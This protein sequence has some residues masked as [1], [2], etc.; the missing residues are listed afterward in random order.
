MDK[1]MVFE[2]QEMSKDPK[3]YYKILELSPGAS[4][5]DVKRAYT[6]QQ[7]K[8]H[9]DSPY[10]KDRLRKAANDQEREKIRKECDEISSQLNS[11]KSVLF[12]EKRKQ[13]Y[14]SGMGEFGAQFGAGN[15]SDIFDIFSQFTGGRGQQRQN[16]MNPTKYVINISLRES[17]VGK[18]SKFNVKTEKI[19][20]KCDGK[21][22]E[23]VET[24][25]KC[26]G[27]GY[28]TSRR[29][30]GGFVTVAES[31]CDACEG[32]GYK[33]K[34]K[35]C[36]SC[37]GAEY[38]QDK[39]LFEVNIKPG[40]RKG[41]KIVFEGMGDQRRRIAPGDVIFIVDVQDDSRFERRGDDLVGKID[42]PLRTAIGGGVVYFNHIDGR[43]LEITVNPFRTFDTVLKIRNEGFRGQRTGNLVLKPNIVIGSEADRAKIM[44]ALDAPVEK[45]YGAFTKVNSEFGAMPEAEREHEEG[46][47]SD[48]AGHSA[49]S[50]FNSFSFF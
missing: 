36:D 4:I 20:P 11:A 28:Y 34:G 15:Y 27:N 10:M 48:D 50:F 49:R 12:D 30:L 7:V 19:C 3:G 29:N 17:Y 45:P 41:E 43:K 16:K 44:Q 32:S 8:Y 23:N 42:I 25:K 2:T 14:D 24:C 5:A 33:I 18:V 40:T 47:A 37:K 38:I 21:G 13:Q 31:R 35:V 9:P 39:T 1:K 22:G 6:K 26:E 46:Y